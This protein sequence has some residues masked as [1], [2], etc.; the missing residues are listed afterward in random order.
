[1]PVIDIHNHVT[2]RR[3]VD[4]IEREGSWHTLGS[5][6][7]ELHIPKFSIA[8]NDRIAEMDAMGVD[9]HCLTVNTGFFRYDL[10]AEVARAI[11]DECN[12]EL[13]DMMRTHPDRFTGL[14]SVP[15]QDVPAAIEVM[16]R[17]MNDQGFRGITIGDHVNGVTLDDPRFAP[18]WKAVEELGAVV[19]FHQCSSTVV[20]S[21]T[22]RY[23]LPNVIGNLV[24][25]AITFGTLVYGGVIDRF[26]DLKLCLGHAG[27][28]T[29]FGIA[30][31]D[32]GWQAGAMENMPEFDDA[33]TFLER[34][35]SEYVRRF[36]YDSCTYTE[37]TLRYLLD[38]V[39]SDRVVL[40]TDYPAPMM[41][42]DPVPWIQA[43]DGLTSEEKNAVLSEN[44][45]RLLGI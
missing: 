34:A 7:G 11:A 2:P 38:M 19:F 43:M 44:P 16:T 31:M 42:P 21:R 28:Y 18:F 17:A 1:M 10:D 40:G 4:A 12:E 39:G 13:A 9:I 41:E 32:K 5:D 30:R 23:G 20:E 27:G 45:A 29:A 25:R 8:P 37:S 33:R 24:D 35:P 36:W 22:T 15:M 3:F 6:V 26:P 14:A